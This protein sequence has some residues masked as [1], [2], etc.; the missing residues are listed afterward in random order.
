VE[1]VVATLSREQARAI[2]WD[3]TQL[4]IRFF[5]AFD[6]WR[7]REMVEL[8]APDGVWHRQGKPLRGRDAILSALEQR[9]T[10]Q[11]V[12]HVVTNIQ[13]T[14]VDDATADT[15]LYVTAY[16]HDTGEKS[17]AT[18]VIR[19]PSLLLTVPG[20]LVSTEGGWRISSLT[21]TRVFE[22]RV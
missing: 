7:Y 14:A 11:T 22:F 18:P 5:N 16:Q 6:A 20:T 8:F 19:A 15:L 4:L 13:V 21:M 12:R 2:E 3:C 10:T 17:T 1:R 9:S